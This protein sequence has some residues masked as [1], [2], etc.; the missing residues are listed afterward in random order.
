MT[1][2]VNIAEAKARLSELVARAEAGEDIVLARAGKPA[3]RLVP[4][5]VSERPRHFRIGAFAHHGPVSEEFLDLFL[6]PDPE[7]DPDK[8]I[9]PSE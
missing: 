9:F 8:D 4:T 6:E 5:G 3:I 1:T 2:Q 7:F